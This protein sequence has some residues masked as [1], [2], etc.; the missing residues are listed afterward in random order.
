VVVRQISEGILK[1]LFPLVLALASVGC[2]PFLHTETPIATNFDTSRQLKLQA[3]HHW[4]VIANDMADTI[5]KNLVQ[6]SVCVPGSPA[7]STLFVDMPTAV[8]PFGEAFHSQFKSRLVSSG[9]PVLT[10]DAAD[11]KISVEAQTVKFSPNRSQY[12]G[13]GRFT[14]LS[15]G[16]WALHEININ[17]SVGAAVF[18]GSV[19]ADLVE[20]NNSQF[21]KGPTPQLELILT[22][23]ATKNG[24]YLA[25][26][27]SVYYIS[28]SDASLYCWK[29]HKCGQVAVAPAPVVKV[30]GDC[31]PGFCTTADTPVAGGV[32]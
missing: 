31:G 27:T 13:A 2:A 16:V 8:S 19:L 18:A 6:G 4:Q 26:S 7:C 15:T 5:S 17:E 23:S 22:V 32:K 24:R 21:A 1:K 29:A 28:D 10:S 9:V 20:W 14:L 11:V 30:V 12:L 3:A 25:R